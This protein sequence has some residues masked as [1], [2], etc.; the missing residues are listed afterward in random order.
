MGR[1]Y[2]GGCR[3]LGGGPRDSRS[4]WGLGSSHRRSSQGGT[5]TEAMGGELCSGGVALAF[6]S[7]LGRGNQ[8]R[9]EGWRITH[10]LRCSQQG[11]LTVSTSSIK[12][13]HLV[14]II[15]IPVIIPWRTSKC[16][17]SRHTALYYRTAQNLEIMGVD[18]KEGMPRKPLSKSP[19]A[20]HTR[21][22]S[23]PSYHPLCQL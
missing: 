12:Q 11:H 16:I 2:R 4:L 10:N 20:C 8:L 14:I 23:M 5:N 17:I 22:S 9:G 19:S 1:W 7:A 15:V 6:A 13:I 21:G 18:G 3:G